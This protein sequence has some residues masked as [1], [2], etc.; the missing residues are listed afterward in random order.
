MSAR[1][2]KIGILSFS[3]LVTFIVP[4]S[5]GD[6][7]LPVDPYWRYQGSMLAHEIISTGTLPTANDFSLGSSLVDWVSEFI[8]DL[9]SPLFVIV[10][11]QIT[12]RSILWGF[13]LPIF[14][15][16]FVL[17]QALV[18]KQLH[19]HPATFPTAIAVGIGY[20][21]FNFG[22]LDMAHRA[23]AGWALLFFFIASAHL[24]SDSSHRSSDFTS[25][26]WYLLLPLTV[27]IA[28]LLYYH[29]LAI[30]GLV[31]F[32]VYSLFDGIE[33][34][35]I[36]RWLTLFLILIASLYYSGLQSNWLGTIVTKLL[37]VFQGV[38]IG[39]NSILFTTTDLGPLSPYLLE[40]TTPLLD[41]LVIISSAVAAIVAGSVTLWRLRV[42]YQSR[43]IKRL[44]AF[45]LAITVL[46]ALQLIPFVLFSV[47]TATNPLELGLYTMPIFAGIAV[48]QLISWQQHNR[49]LSWSQIGRVG[50][51]LM[52]ITLPAFGA[53]TM[54]PTSDHLQLKNTDQTDIQTANWS[55]RYS[56]GGLL[57]SFPFVSTYLATQGRQEVYLPDP[58]AEP[59]D[60]ISKYYNNP[61]DTDGLYELYVITETMR[62]QGILHINSIATR[63]SPALDQKFSESTQWAKVYSNGDDSTYRTPGDA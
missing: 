7:V 22:L 14:Y 23:T 56:D 12:G 19:N 36:P 63:P 61:T 38:T 11:S 41:K 62:N 46:V 18:A 17:S 44:D 13:S 50:I 45:L 39:S 30:V 51:V 31:F 8:D 29:T 42:M 4:V 10:L 48:S 37:L 1:R 53:T 32:S 33:K 35:T 2:W 54:M 24:Y 57:S 28:F 58:K 52:L 34:G 16:V 49:P 55:N 60:V 15:P 20:H 6:T 40:F 21:Y 3:L 26:F 43:T 9:A 25:H 59:E 47:S 27:G 5:R